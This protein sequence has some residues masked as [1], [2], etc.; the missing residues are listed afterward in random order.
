MT[1]WYGLKPFPLLRFEL[2]PTWPVAE[3][4]PATMLCQ[5]IKHG[6]VSI[7]SCGDQNERPPKFR[8]TTDWRGYVNCETALNSSSD[9][10]KVTA[11]M[12]SVEQTVDHLWS[13]TKISVRETSTEFNS[14]WK[15]RGMEIEVPP[16][17][18]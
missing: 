10:V 7:I 11:E 15:R 4:N 6:L 13:L 12:W 14:I 3:D 8:G 5:P 16:R 18:A 9:S 1:N 17:S 2:A